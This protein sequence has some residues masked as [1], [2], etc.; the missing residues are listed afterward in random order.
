M[1]K[2]AILI[3]ALFVNQKNWQI[4][5]N[6]IFTSNTQI[7]TEVDNRAGEADVSPHWPLE[8]LRSGQDPHLGVIASGVTD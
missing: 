4:Q 2:M 7:P 1:A 3:S 5:Q 8:G 6:R